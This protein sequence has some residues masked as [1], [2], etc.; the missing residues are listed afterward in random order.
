MRWGPYAAA[1][2]GS[3]QKLREALAGGPARDKDRKEPAVA[4]GILS[5]TPDPPEA[6]EW[7]NKSVLDI[8][9]ADSS[10][11][12]AEDAAGDGAVCAAAV[13]WWCALPAAQAAGLTCCLL[14]HWFM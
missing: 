11:H 9:A 2:M 7:R 14:F 13:V 5:V 6:A 4:D 1:D 12:Q 8:V 3:S 10:F